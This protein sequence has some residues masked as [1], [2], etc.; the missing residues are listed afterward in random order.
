[1]DKNPFEEETNTLVV[2]AHGALILLANPVARGQVLAITN[3]ATRQKLTCRVAYLEPT[4][5]GRTQ[6]GIEFT[7]PSP[8]FWQINFPPEDWKA[9]AS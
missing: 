4:Q 5:G 3:C 6:V 7:Q 1:V 8:G 9:P 2:N